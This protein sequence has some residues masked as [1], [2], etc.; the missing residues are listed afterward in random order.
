MRRNSNIGWGTQQSI[1]QTRNMTLVNLVFVEIDNLNSLMVFIR[2]VLLASHLASASDRQIFYPRDTM[3]KH[4]LFRRKMAVCLSV[5]L[6]HIV[7]KRL[8]LS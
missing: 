8:N 3:R 4:G 1:I 2:G 6:T 5:C 7:S